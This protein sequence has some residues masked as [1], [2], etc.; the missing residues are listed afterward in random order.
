MNRID[1]VVLLGVGV[2]REIN[3]KHYNNYNVVIIITID[4]NQRDEQQ[5]Q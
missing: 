4:K 1:S 3:N 2:V 5:Q